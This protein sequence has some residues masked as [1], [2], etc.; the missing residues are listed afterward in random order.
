MVEDLEPGSRAAGGADPLQV[1]NKVGLFQPR[2][3]IVIVEISPCLFSFSFLHI[4]PFVGFQS[5]QSPRKFR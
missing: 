4:L 1:Q 5:L 3:F 2:G